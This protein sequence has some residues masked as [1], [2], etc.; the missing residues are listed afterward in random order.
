MKKIWAVLCLIVFCSVSFGFS[1]PDLNLLAEPPVL[2]D[3]HGQEIRGAYG[4]KWVKLDLNEISDYAE[5]AFIAAEDKNF[6]RHHGVD[7]VAVL[8]A[9]YLNLRHGRVVAG[10]STITQQTAKNLFLTQERTMLRKIKELFYTFLL[11]IRYSKDEILSLYLSSIYFGEGATGIEAGARTY[12]GKSARDLDLAESALLAGI[13]RRP[14]YYDPYKHPDHAKSRQKTVLKLMVKA[15]YITEEEAAEA[16]SEKLVFRKTSYLPGDAP[17]FYDMVMD[18]LVKKYGPQAAY[19]GGL[20]VFTTLD[21]DMQRKAETAFAGVMKDKNPHLQGALVAVD[22]R[23]GGIRALI[24]GRNFAE[25]P[26]NRA[27]LAKRPPGSAFKPFLYSLALKSGYTEASTIMCEPVWF[28]QEGAPDYH[29]TDYGEEPYHYRLFTL[30]EAVMISDNIVAVRLNEALG[31]QNVASHARRFGFSGPI[32]PVLSLALGTSEVTPLEMARAFAAFASGGELPRPFYIVKVVDRYGRELEANYP[33]T[34]RIISRQ[35]AYL[36]TDM[37]MAVF[38]PGGTAS[39]LKSLVKRTAAGKTG[40]TQNYRDAWFVGYTPELSC[41]VWVGWEQGEGSVGAPGGR[42]AGPI[43][44]DFMREALKG[45]PDRGFTVPDGIV[46]KEICM[47]TGLLASEYCPR[48]MRFAFLKDTEPVDYCQLH[49][50][51]VSWWDGEWSEPKDQKEEKHPQDSYLFFPR[52]IR[53]FWHLV[54]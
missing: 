49:E 31:P 5:K 39:H 51:P 27:L 44:A 34:Q 28:S 6:Y 52:W 26:Y 14:V 20:K 2:Y 7:I 42:I 53:R 10:G 50:P 1:W 15:G 40:T 35:N 54:R 46:E 22:V 33:V 13:P 32:K 36:V 9:L 4:Q 48:P 17:Y 41:A 11:E 37:L 23:S 38:E 47:D 16:A 19:G 25:A 3:I 29:P 43:W 18:Y 12:F 21:L 24:G 8:R 45:V 30:K